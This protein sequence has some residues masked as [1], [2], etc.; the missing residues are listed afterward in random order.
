M[1]L[2]RDMH[3]RSDALATVATLCGASERFDVINISMMND[4]GVWL[5]LYHILKPC[6]AFD[7]RA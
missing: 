2:V 6:P 5:G 7:T 1:Q 3:G 4:N